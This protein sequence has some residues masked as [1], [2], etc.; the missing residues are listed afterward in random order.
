MINELT[1]PSPAATTIDRI[2][3]LIKLMRKTQ[4][5][6]GQLINV[7]AS[8]MSKFL[9]G[10]I[11]ITDGFINRI[12]V[13]LNVSKKWLLTG[14]DVP[15]PKGAEPGVVDG[16]A[17]VSWGKGAPVYDI[18]VTAGYGELSRAFTDDRIIGTLDLPQLD[19]TTPVVRVSGESMLPRICNGAY[20]SVRPISLD[21]P[22]FWG[23]IYVVI[24]DDYRMCKVLKRHSDPDKVILHSF[25]P[26]FDDME[27]K[28][29]AIRQ[30]FAVDLIINYEILG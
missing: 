21:S 29:S 18:D 20:V 10:R 25:N 24:L 15:F 30:L 26:E 11:P 1:P 13:N 23:S 22:I 16:G 9:S 8:N 4:A 17:R 7:D 27:V 14:E 28:R 5:Q 19:P 3:Y 12:V 2:K 6:F